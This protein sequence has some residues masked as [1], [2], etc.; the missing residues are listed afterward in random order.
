MIV[1]LNFVDWVIIFEFD[2]LFYFGY[3]KNIWVGKVGKLL[4][5]RCN[6]DLGGNFRGFMVLGYIEG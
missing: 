6:R 1:L 2:R 4:L 5:F 3:F